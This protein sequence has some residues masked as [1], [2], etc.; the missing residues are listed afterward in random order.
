VLKSGDITQYKNYS[1][2]PHRML[3]SS[4]LIRNALLG[5]SVRRQQMSNYHDDDT[6][7]Y[8]TDNE[9]YNETVNLIQSAMLGHT[10]RKANM[11]NSQ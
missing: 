1:K 5:H 4:S 6:D 7:V 8:E 11:R 3:Q 10:S 2:F 9:D